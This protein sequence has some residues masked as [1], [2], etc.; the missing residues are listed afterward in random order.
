MQDEELMDLVINLLKI[1]RMR[2]SVIG[3]TKLVHTKTHL[4]FPK[5][6]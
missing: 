1:N 6:L 3:E 4:Q 2:K 5:V